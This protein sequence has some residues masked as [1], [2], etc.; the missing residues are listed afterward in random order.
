MRYTQVILMDTQ[1][2]NL[3][4]HA[5]FLPHAPFLRLRSRASPLSSFHGQCQLILT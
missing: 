1:D 4:P 2:G 5:D 3:L